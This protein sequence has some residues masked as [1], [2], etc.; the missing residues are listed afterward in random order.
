MSTD[1][2]T[3]GE[4][5]MGTDPLR[6]YITRLRKLAGLDQEE[7]GERVGMGRRT[8]HAWESGSTKDIKFPLLRKVVQEVGG[9]FQHLEHIDEM[10][11]EEAEH[12]AE[13]WHAMSADEQA[14]ASHGAQTIERMVSLAESDP[15]RLESV[16]RR[17]RD[18]AREDTE[19]I[20]LVET[21]LDGYK[22]ATR[23]LKGK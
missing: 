13:T 16:L 9:A 2:A 8:Y 22:A 1:V 23:R 11:V 4:G 19:L 17:L 14:A 15:V 7:L 5:S 10:S 3:I 6:A 21:Y 20:D 18:E 12:L